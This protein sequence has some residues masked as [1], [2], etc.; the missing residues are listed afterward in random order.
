[1]PD[2]TLL[3]RAAVVGH[4]DVIVELKKLADRTKNEL[5]VMHLQT[6]TTI[7]IVPASAK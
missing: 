3:W 7:A 1:M 5:R 2:D 4:D 6:K